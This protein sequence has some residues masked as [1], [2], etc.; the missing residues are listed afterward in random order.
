MRS[1]VN[2]DHWHPPH[3]RGARVLLRRPRADDLAAIRRWYADP[4]LTRLTRYQT[5]PMSESEVELFFRS[6]LLSPD[7]L[8]YSILELPAERLVGFTTFSALDV[9][10]GSVLFHITIGER[11]AWNRGLGTESTELMLRHAF[12]RL[13][14]H[15]VGLTVFS[16]NQ[17]AIRAYE[18]AG[19]RLEG[20]MREAVERDGR[21]WDEV[22]MGV[23]R[24]EWLARAR[25]ATELPTRLAPVES[26]G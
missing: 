3:L 25:T 11:D 5:R 23:L 22:Q 1:D 6:R 4:E 13:G 19:F 8:A 26:T 7:A 16:F 20:R 18:K 15:R 10:N 12:E 14:L 21:Y 2:R 9:D 24:E 17:R